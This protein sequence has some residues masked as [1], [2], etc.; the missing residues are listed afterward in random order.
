MLRAA[1]II[2]AILVAILTIRFFTGLILNKAPQ[3]AFRG[4]GPQDVEERVPAGSAFELPT[5]NGFILA[6]MS[7]NMPGDLKTEL[8]LFPQEGMK[9]FSQKYAEWAPEPFSQL[10]GPQGPFGSLANVSSP[11]V[12]RIMHIMSGLDD[13]L[14][15]RMSEHTVERSFKCVKS[16]IWLGIA[17]VSDARW[18]AKG[19]D[20]E[21][22][23]EEALAI[24]QQVVDV[25]DYLRKPEIQGQMRNVHNKIWA[26]IDIF[27]D[28]C[29][30]VR[31]TKGEPAPDFSLTKLWQEYVKYHF[32]FMQQ[33]AR[34]WMFKRLKI[35]HGVWKSRLLATMQ[36]GRQIS[37]T[38]TTIRIEHYAMMILNKILDLY[39][40]ADL[41]I[42]LRTDGFVMSH[43][44]HKRM[45]KLDAPQK[46][47]N[48]IY[49]EIENQRMSGMTAFLQAVITERVAA[50][51]Q[52]MPVPDFMEAPQMLVDREFGHKSIQP[53][54][55]TPPPLKTE[56]WV[57]N[58]AEK[59]VERF[60]FVI[61]R[62]T[63]KESDEEWVEFLA[64]LESGL[65]SGWDGVLGAESIRGKEYLNWIDGKEIGIAEGD[66][67]AARKHFQTITQS[68]S[69][70]SGISKHI[71]LAI[72]PS[73]I[74]A[75]STQAADRKGDYRGFLQVIESDYDPSESK[76]RG[77]KPGYDGS[78][79]IIDQ[80][81]WTDLYAMNI[82]SGSQTFQE[83]WALAAEH[84]GAVYVGPTTG[85]RR[86][87]WREMKE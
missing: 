53:E 27:Q 49:S 45:T 30:A 32:L 12:V 44:I 36:S 68:D 73:S 63:C 19:L 43:G 33:Q 34:G 52:R 28:A 60:G 83:Y 6:A 86:R 39:R 76:Q 10:P 8:P 37:E 69:F 13:L 46:E 51:H 15:L 84:P 3:P 62:L 87:D 72:T 38:K 75:F 17:P 42:R 50:R 65:S 7:G 11:P 18:C 5:M 57:R 55:E 9:Y 21:A 41:A 29:N 70:L 78:F 82:A 66:I 23:I 24:L 26:E 59:Q 1:E 64:K 47:L 31:T 67:A 56:T 71:F 35:L 80:L 54:I 16:K 81:V 48:R 79:K 40:D 25:F 2:I 77:Y 61:Y 20:E 85:V 74:K 22:N 4:A 58:L 14:N